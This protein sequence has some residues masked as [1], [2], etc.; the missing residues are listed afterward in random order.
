MKILEARV[1]EYCLPLTQ[2][3][4]LMGTEMRDRRGFLLEFRDATV[5]C[6]FGEIAPFPGLHSESLSSAAEQLRQVCSLWPGG[7]SFNNL[8][9]FSKF[10]SSNFSENKHLAPSVLFGLE[11]A[12]LNLRAATAKKTVAKILNSDARQTISVNGLLTGVSAGIDAEIERIIAEKYT[13]V[14]MKVGRADTDTEL[15]WIANVSKKL[16]TTVSLRLDANRRWTLPEAVAYGKL[17]GI[18]R[19]EYIEEPLQNPADLA[20]FHRQ[21]GLP[22]ALDES[23]NGAD[24]ENFQIPEGTVAF[25]LKPSVLGISGTLRW[26]EFA[27]KNGVSVVISS[28]FESGLGLDMLA[29]IAAAVNVA[30]V[31]SGLDTWRWLAS[32]IISSRFSVNMGKYHISK[33]VLPEMAILTRKF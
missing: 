1:F 32:D 27:N 33:P 31:P 25:I 26:A 12:Y 30:D 18:E 15:E 7:K 16:P 4:N 20:E 11:M 8:D 23:L 9:E 22:L 10:V 29:N 17:S 24:P 21:T 13:A 14:K 2:P 6:G 3:L 5:N 28:A 19:I